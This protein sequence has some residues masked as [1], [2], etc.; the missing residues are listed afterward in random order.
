MKE[1][2][3]FE[4]IPA[5][6]NEAEESEFWATHCLGDELLEQMQPIEILAEDLLDINLLSINL[7]L[8]IHDFDVNDR[9]FFHNADK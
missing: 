6:E 1:I 3:S 2:N 8:N 5:F 9:Y 4:K 7:G